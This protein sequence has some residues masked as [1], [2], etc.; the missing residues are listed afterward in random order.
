MQDRGSE[1]Q[2]RGR[3]LSDYSWY[4][5]QEATVEPLRGV[6][7]KRAYLWHNEVSLSY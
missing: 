5:S 7:T 4:S 1:M 6:G 3:N 2:D